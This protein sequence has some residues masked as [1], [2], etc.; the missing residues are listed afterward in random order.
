MVSRAILARFNNVERRTAEKQDELEREL[1]KA[2]EN[3]HGA[4]GLIISL[5]RDLLLKRDEL[6]STVLPEVEKLLPTAINRVHRSYA[7]ATFAVLL[8]C[9]F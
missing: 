9:M 5:G 8:V 7:L 4:A 2:M 6:I 1:D 3:A